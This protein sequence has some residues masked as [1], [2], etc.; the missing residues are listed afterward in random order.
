MS[1]WT[2]GVDAG[3][4]VCG[5]GAQEANGVKWVKWVKRHRGSCPGVPGLSSREQQR[6]EEG[7]RSHRCNAFCHHLTAIANLW[8]TIEVI[9]CLQVHF[10]CGG[11][12]HADLTRDHRPTDPPS[13]LLFCPDACRVTSHAS[14]NNPTV[15][16]CFMSRYNSTTHLGFTMSIRINHTAAKHGRVDQSPA[17]HHIP[18]NE[19]RLKVKK[20]RASP[21][22]TCEHSPI[23]AT[24]PVCQS[25][26]SK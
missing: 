26:R 10:A 15:S 19:T 16:S 23:P 14:V 12:S 21:L 8:G 5:S 17:S 25:F 2:L 3:S 6:E 22:Q 18:T 7:G 4:W 1:S 9:A 20:C 11:G 13:L 24:R